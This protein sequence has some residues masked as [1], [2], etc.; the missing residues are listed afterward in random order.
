MCCRIRFRP[1][2]TSR[3][4]RRAVGGVADAGR[5]PAP[6]DGRHV[7]GHHGAEWPRGTRRQGPRLADRASSAGTVCKTIRVRSNCA[8]ASLP[9]LPAGERHIFVHNADRR[10]RVG[11]AVRLRRLVAQTAHPRCPWGN[12]TCCGRRSQFSR[13]RCTGSAGIRCRTR[14]GARGTRTQE[15]FKVHM[16]Q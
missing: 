12:P 3:L 10:R 7:P 4:A 8:L 14:D 16:C 11:S 5:P 2:A 15:C 13:G 9:T 1:A 6:R